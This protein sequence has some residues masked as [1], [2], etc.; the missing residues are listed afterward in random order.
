MGTILRAN[1]ATTNPTLP[2]G[3]YGPWITKGIPVYFIYKSG[4]THFII[5]ISDGGRYGMADLTLAEY[6]SVPLTEYQ[7]HRGTFTKQISPFAISN[8]NTTTDFV[9]TTLS[10]GFNNG[11]L[12]R[13]GVSDGVLPLALSTTLKYQVA[14][15]T[16]T[17]FKVK[18]ADG[19]TY[20]DFQ[21]VGSGNLIVWKANAG[22]DD[23]EQ[24][25][26]TW[27]PEFDST[28]SNIAYV[29]GR[30]SAA[31]SHATN[32]PDW[33]DFR[34]AGN[35]RRLMDYD[36]EGNELGVVNGSNAGEIKTL[37]LA[38]LHVLDNYLVGYKGDI[39]RIDFP[40]WRA[41]RDAAEIEVW[42]RIVTDITGTTH[43]LIARYYQ[44]DDYTNLILTR[45]DLEV[46]IPST[47]P[48]VPP[49]PG[50]IGYGFSIIL[51]GKIKFEFSETYT[52]S[53]VVDD[54]VE[55]W[56]D[57]TRILHATTV[58]THT[59]QRAFIANQVYQIEIRF[60]QYQNTGGGNL[61][62][63]QF[64]W[65]SASQSLEIVPSDFL[66]PSDEIVLQYGNVG[67][68]FPT[69]TEASEVHERLMERCPGW[70]WTDSNGKI[71]FLAPDRAN[72]FEFRFDRPDD[73]SQ[74][75]FVYG[76]F[77][78]T[79]RPLSERRNLKLGKGRNSTQTGYPIFYVQVDRDELRDLSN[80]EPSNDPAIELGVCTRSL[81]ERMMEMDLKIKSDPTHVF[82]ISGV[83][84][85]SII[86]KNDFITVY[87]IDLNGNFVADV[88]GLVTSHSWGARNSRNDFVALP[89][90]GD[91]YSV[92]EVTS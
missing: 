38:P 78:K 49:A 68:A 20:I 51:S 9:T 77:Q 2:G 31:H 65:Q 8:I 4:R 22:W 90:E 47:G 52:L 72:A 7:Y 60:R 21:D 50:V 84:G 18:T 82:N 43:G 59:V 12:I 91:Y 5:L 34:F 75:N 14:D 26:P 37:S 39:N 89:I 24:G 23:P 1:D 92:E 19:A 3:V 28:F 57:G 46:N 30:L 36:D 64:K 41:L 42:Q 56:I 85:S 13:F 55:L 33:D 32:A 67:M 45:T 88:T 81:A 79:R 87:Y 74:A 63:C 25:L 15:K 80:G 62:Q 83:R 70:D 11:D 40:S 73:D 76:S 6:K 35:G 54:E 44:G 17:T 69:P 10:H 48:G 86:R 53:F 71:V 58:G 16:A 29:E 27:C 61:Y 66:Y